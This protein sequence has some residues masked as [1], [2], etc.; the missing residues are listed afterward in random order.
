MKK[1]TVL[2]LFLP[3][4]YSV[5][6][7]WEIINEGGMHNEGFISRFIGDIDFFNENIGWI[8]CQFELFLTVD[9]G[10]TWNKVFQRKVDYGEIYDAVFV[11]NMVGY[12]IQNTNLH[13]TIDGGQSWSTLLSVGHYGK[14]QAVNENILFVSGVKV[15]DPYND[16]HVI[17]KTLDGGQNW[18]E[19][20]TPY[21]DSWISDYYFVNQDYGYV[22]YSVGL[23]E[24]VNEENLID[25]ATATGGQYFFADSASNIQPIFDLIYSEIIL[26]T[27]PTNVNLVEVTETYIVDESDFSI[28]PD[29]IEEIDGKTVISWFDISQY[30]GDLDE[31]LS[32]DETFVTT[33]RM[34]LDDRSVR[35]FF[36]CVRIGK[37][38]PAGTGVTGN[39]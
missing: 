39:L 24:G 14:V 23:G 20:N 19:I 22:I 4:L 28:T 34:A 15:I 26:S 18:E 30:V 9:R 5:Q 33:Y 12:V 35:S 21:S 36:G 1:L 29:S 31:Y 25:M 11:N 13:K 8:E 38:F 7:Q 10:D 6:A 37:D 32:E 2:L 27:S 3:M 16:K 17:M